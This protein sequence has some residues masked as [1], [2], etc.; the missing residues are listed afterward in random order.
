MSTYFINLKIILD[1]S[2]QQNWIIHS[3]TTKSQSVG[4]FATFLG[5]PFVFLTFRHIKASVVDAYVA[6][7]CMGVFLIGLGVYT[8]LFSENVTVIVD[9]ERKRLM[10][11]KKN[12]LSSKSLILGFGEIASVNVTQI[13]GYRGPPTYHLNIEQKNGKIEKTGRWAFEQG[14]I[15]ALAERLSFAAGCKFN[16]GVILHPID[17]NKIIYSG[18]GAVIVYAVWFRIWAGPLC[19]AM[20]HGSAPPLIIAIAFFSVLSILR[21]FVPGR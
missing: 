14:E 6:G 13:G 8:L 11:Q 9:T 16:V 10:L 20:W 4:L 17:L 18:I 21:K 12:R 5:I 15:V 1:V 7:F 2:N 19:P 3:S